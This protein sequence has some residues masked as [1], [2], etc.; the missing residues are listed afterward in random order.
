MTIHDHAHNLARSLNQSPE[1]QTF[2]ATK[3]RLETDS[4][5]KQM[6]ADFFLKKMEIEYAVMAG[7]PEEQGKIDELQQ[8]YQVLSAHQPAQEFI[9]A[10]LRFQQ[11]LGDVYKILGDSVAEGLDFFAKKS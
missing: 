11:L 9:Q 4:Q 5:L 6:V 8:Q 2:L 1:Y 3:G 7:Q 10:Q